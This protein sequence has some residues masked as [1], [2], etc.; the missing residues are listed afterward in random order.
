MV[1]DAVNSPAALPADPRQMP[2][3]APT[4]AP[5]PGASPEPRKPDAVPAYDPAAALQA[6]EAAIN[7]LNESVK[8]QLRDLSFRE[9]EVSGRSVISVVSSKTGDV[10]RQIPSDVALS[11]ARQIENVLGAFFDKRA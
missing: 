10:I 11:V 1:M 7:D 9:D 8:S 6:L 2:R 5:N 4:A 3:Q